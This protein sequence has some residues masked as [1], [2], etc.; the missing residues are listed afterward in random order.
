MDSQVSDEFVLGPSQP[1]NSSL[2]VPPSFRLFCTVGRVA[3]NDLWSNPTA[4][5]ILRDI[6]S[7]LSCILKEAVPSFDFYSGDSVI[8]SSLPGAAKYPLCTVYLDCAYVSGQVTL[9]V[10][11]TLPVSSVSVLVGHDLAGAQVVPYPIVPA[12][13]LLENNTQK[14]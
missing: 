5:T 9:A 7:D 6:G 13:P 10:V 3:A 12:V 14:L 8:V 11:D 4:V 1:R 2:D